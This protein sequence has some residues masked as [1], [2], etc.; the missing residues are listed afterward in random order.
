MKI[1][2]ALEDS[3]HRVALT[4]TGDPPEPSVPD[5]ALLDYARCKVIYRF[6]LSSTSS[7]AGSSVIESGSPTMCDQA[8]HT[9]RGAPGS[10]GV[11][12]VSVAQDEIVP[13]PRPL[14]SQGY[15][16]PGQTCD[17][18]VP[19]RGSLRTHADDERTREVGQTYSTWEVP[20]QCRATGCGPLAHKTGGRVLYSRHAHF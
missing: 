4:S 20:E 13:D 5:S 14:A 17:L 15:C 16:G 9:L 11:T 1:V 7:P 8:F 3:E 2:P 6:G 12:C 10:A 18:P 19:M